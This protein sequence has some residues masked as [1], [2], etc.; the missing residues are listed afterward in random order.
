V[1]NGRQGDI[2]DEIAQMKRDSDNIKGIQFIGLEGLRSYKTFIPFPSQN[3]FSTTI[4][5]TQPIRNFLFTF[6]H[7]ASR[8]ALLQLNVFTRTDNPDVMAN[9]IPYQTPTAPTVT[10]RWKKDVPVGDYQTSWHV[11]FQK[12]LPGFPSFQLYAK[13]FIDGTATGTWTFVEI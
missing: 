12:N 10:T 9:P 2:I 8:K 3:D 13:F 6:S 5:E 1:L 4:A 7:P 11:R